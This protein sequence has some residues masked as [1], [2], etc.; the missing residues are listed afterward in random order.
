MSPEPEQG[1]GRQTSTSSGGSADEGHDGGVD[2]ERKAERTG[3]VRRLNA[4][5][6]EAGVLAGISN[7]IDDNLQLFR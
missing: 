6:G 5:V 1:K 4:N 7:A 3:F 2:H